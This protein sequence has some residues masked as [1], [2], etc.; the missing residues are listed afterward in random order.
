MKSFK[1]HFEEIQRG[2]YP[3][4]WKKVRDQL[5]KLRKVVSAPFVVPIILVIRLIRPS[6]YFRFG[7][8]RVDRIGHFVADSALTLAESNLNQKNRYSDWY[9]F[10][11]AV[12]NQQWSKMVKRSFR[13]RWWVQ[14]LYF[15]NSIIPGGDVHTRNIGPDLGSRDIHGW[16]QSSE[17]IQFKSEEEK[18]AKCWLSKQGWKEGESFVCFIIRDASYLIKS[19]LHGWTHEQGLYHSYRDSDIATYVQAAEYL[20]EQGIWVLRMGKQVAK[21]FPSKHPKII[22]YAFHPEKSDLLDIW[23]FANCY[24]SVSSSCGPDEICNFYNRP[25]VLV[26]AGPL[27]LCYSWSD[28]IW[29]PKNLV[30]GKNRKNLTLKEY[31]QHKYLHTQHYENTGIEI[32]DVSSDEITEAVT[33]KLMRIQGV[34]IDKD[35]NVK[36]QQQFWKQFKSW[37]E[38]SKYHDWIH[39]EARMGA[40]FLEKMGDSFLK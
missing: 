21:P 4:F 37:V 19:S 33:E 2:G 18:K 40:Y 12:C 13:I 39:P 7:S 38:F 31:L 16:H 23:L 11:S 32:I 17:K 6:I 25:L 26:N 27:A 28:F 36:Q 5:Q 10:S 15:W 8:F 35:E 14:D 24:F 1:L 20:A 34:W 30:W 22:D 3:V 9:Y 29:V